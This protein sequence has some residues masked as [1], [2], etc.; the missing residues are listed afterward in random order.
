METRPVVLVVDDTETNIDVLLGVLT[1]HYEVSVAMDGETALEIAMED[2]PDIILLDI[3]MPGMDG[4]EVCRRLKVREE[5]RNIPVI[6]ITAKNDVVD[7]AKGFE[8]GG[9]DYIAKPISPPIILARIK[10]HLRLKSALE[11]L[12]NQNHILEEKVWQR[13]R[14]LRETQLKIIRKLCRAAEFRDNE[15]GFH[16]MRMSQY[17]YIIGLKYGMDEKKATL[18]LN[19]APMHDVG[20]IGIP[21]SILLKPDRLSPKEFEVIQ[22][23]PAIGA[24]IIG[25]EESPL[26]KMAYQIAMTHHEKWDGTGYPNGTRGVEIPLV[27]RIAAIADVF[28]A[29]TSKR[30]YKEA[31]STEKSL[32]WMQYQSGKHFDPDLIHSFLQGWDE[33]MMVKE[34]FLDQ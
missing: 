5:T 19:S 4:Y 31:W 13:T 3:M 28:D 2:Q 22:K 11:A 10:T 25:Q 7:E 27:G 21:D 20:K 29:L 17:A 12:E 24:E 26:L 30:P 15:T 1:D 32:E 8:S 34:K 14:A 23:H 16:V 9:I 18:L 6:F 33:I